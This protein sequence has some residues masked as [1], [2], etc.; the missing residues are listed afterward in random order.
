[1]GSYPLKQGGRVEVAMM[2]R[3]WSLSMARRKEEGGKK[4]RKH[5]LQKTP[6]VLRKLV[7]LLEQLQKL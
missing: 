2:A 1:M 5:I 6:W 4:D 3:R 7:R